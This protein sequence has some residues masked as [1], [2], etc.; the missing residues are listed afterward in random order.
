M[1]VS[2]VS[3]GTW[4]SGGD[5]WGKTDDK[6][7]VAAIQKAIDTG[8]NLIDTAPAYGLGHAEEI[9]GKA[10]KGRRDC[11][12]IAT[13]CGL[14]KK[15]KK[16]VLD[17]KPQAIRKEV[18]DSLSRLGIERI[19]LYQCHWP[20]PNAPIEATLEEMLK[21]QSEGK[22]NAIGVSNF[23]VPLLERASKAAQVV[24]VQ[25][26]YSLLE[27]GIEGDLLPFCRREGI[28]VITYGSIGSG[29]LTGKYDERPIFKKND[30]RSYFYRFYSEPRWSLVQDF[31]GEVKKIS[32]E[33]GKSIAQI[34][35]NWILQRGGITSAIVGARTPEQAEMNAGAAEWDLSKDDMDRMDQAYE[36]I[37]AAHEA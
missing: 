17:L 37:F 16:L 7:S 12:F 28:G 22:I 31:L 1:E 15:G 4:V 30:A 2:V 20:D 5:Q 34:A 27:R 29:I 21:M 36:R 3:L 25:P 14:Q 13:K 24:S 19:D 8:I 35:I 32:R 26:H 33:E 10:I 18:E 11:V 9:V 23:D 6:Q